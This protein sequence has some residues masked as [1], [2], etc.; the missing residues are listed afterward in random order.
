MTRW[1]GALNLGVAA[2]GILFAVALG[3][4]L[5]DTRPLPRVP[6]AQTA[7]A[8]A[9]APVRAGSVA[10]RA[11]SSA[12]LESSAYGIIASRNVFDPSRSA[13][14]ATAGL[15]GERPLLYGVV[16]GTGVESRAY[17]ADPVTKV[18]RGYL[19]GDT[20]GGWRLDQ[21]REDRAVFVGP[22]HE[23]LDVLLRDPTKPMPAV[24][25]SV[26]APVAVGAPAAELVAPPA[27]PAGP[28]GQP[29]PAASAA[30]R[31]G[32]PVPRGIGAIPPQ[33]F[34]P[35]RAQPTSPDAM[36]DEHK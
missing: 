17:V 8:V 19:I 25:A 20:V 6:Q 33:L 22:D 12:N 3:R 9:A 15:P 35:A 18:V 31:I 2:L 21:V 24:V 11:D 34:R 10:P 29:A 1:L 4:E 5:A 32:E 14:S 28:L 27:A 16:A 23:R 36:A 13:A 7:P 30:E 26:V